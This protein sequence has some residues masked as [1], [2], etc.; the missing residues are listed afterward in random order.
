MSSKYRVTKGFKFHAR[1]QT[2]AY[3]CLL[4]LADM[5]GVG[6]STAVEIIECKSVNYY[7]N[8]RL[9]F[10]SPWPMQVPG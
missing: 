4:N 5:F 6:V 10:G 2:G 8:Y 7:I 3:S 1:P 9:V